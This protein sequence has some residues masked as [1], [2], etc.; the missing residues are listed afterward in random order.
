[1]ATKTNLPAVAVAGNVLT[2][3]YVND[4]RGAFRVLQVVNATYATQTSN[5]TNTF[6]TTGLTAT[7]T[8]TSTTNKILCIVQQAGI[9]KDNNTYMTLK[10]YR[11]ASE[12]ITFEATAG[13]TATAATN[14]VGTAGT[15]FLDS[16]ATVAA[17]TYTTY[18]MS[19]A[20]IASTT[21]QN[22]SSRSTITLMEISA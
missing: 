22:G 3:A 12:I 5:S 21:V 6:V 4:L 9:G 2:A 11:G 20:N 19:G 14:Y 7:I 1:M 16:P 17:T 10:L 18:F 15:V 13:Y 8:P